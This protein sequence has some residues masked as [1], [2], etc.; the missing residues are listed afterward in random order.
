MSCNVPMRRRT[1]R[2]AHR[3]GALSWARD[4]RIASITT[5]VDSGGGRYRKVSGTLA[6]G[7]EFRADGFGGWAVLSPPAGGAGTKIGLQ[8]NETPQDH[9]LCTWTST[10]SVRV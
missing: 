1:S 10:Y 2:A 4:S 6:L 9:R 3:T 5:P 7:C 8:N